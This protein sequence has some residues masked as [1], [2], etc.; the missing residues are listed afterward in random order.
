MIMSRFGAT[1]ADL[2]AIPI[3]DWRCFHEAA[4]RDRFADKLC[5]TSLEDFF[6]LEVMRVYQFVGDLL[7]YHTDNAASLGNCAEQLSPYK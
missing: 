2:V 5:A 6:F 4:G 1:R 7:V 3:E